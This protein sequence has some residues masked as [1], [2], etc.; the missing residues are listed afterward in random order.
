MFDQVLRIYVKHF[1]LSNNNSHFSNYKSSKCSLFKSTIMLVSTP[2]E[3]VKFPI[4]PPFTKIL[5]NVLIIYN[6]MLFLCHRYVLTEMAHILLIGFSLVTMSFIYL[7]SKSLLN[8][9]YELASYCSK[10]IGDYSEKT[11]EH[12]YILHASFYNNKCKY[13]YIII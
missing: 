12:T 4:I 7:F 13:I 8:L 3:K 9:Y 11:M 6:S 1:Y 5:I 2:E 10:C